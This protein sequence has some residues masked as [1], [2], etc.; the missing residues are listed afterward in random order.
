[1]YS[2]ELRK[3]AIDLH[4]RGTPIPEICKHL[5]SMVAAS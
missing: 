3:Q 1:M 5:V 2:S 4:N